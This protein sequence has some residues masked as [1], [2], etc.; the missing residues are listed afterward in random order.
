MTGAVS[1]ILAGQADSAAIGDSLTDYLKL[2][3]LLGQ[4][5]TPEQ[6]LQLLRVS[7]GVLK[8]AAQVMWDS[9]AFQ[10]QFMHV[11]QQLL[12][13]HFTKQNLS[14]TMVRGRLATLGLGC[15]QLVDSDVHG[16]SR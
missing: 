4:Y 14:R 5:N 12:Q 9:A 7:Q 8:Q 15:L 6:Q 1:F 2:L 13:V 16:L 11:T 3:F 10:V